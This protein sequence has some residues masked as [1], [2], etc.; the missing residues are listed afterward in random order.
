MFVLVEDLEGKFVLVEID[1]TSTNFAQYDFLQVPKIV[2]SG[3]PLY[4]VLR[5]KKKSE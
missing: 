2:L 5:F 3:D 4:I 1:F